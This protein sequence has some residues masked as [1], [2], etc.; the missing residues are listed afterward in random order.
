MA[1]PGVITRVGPR[2]G[3]IKPTSNENQGR[4]PPGTYPSAQRC[5]GPGGQGPVCYQGSSQ[6]SLG[7]CLPGPEVPLGAEQQEGAAPA[8]LRASCLAGTPAA[9]RRGGAHP[10]PPRPRATFLDSAARGLFPLLHAPAGPQLHGLGV[11]KGQLLLPP[12]HQKSLRPSCTWSG[13]GTSYRHRCPQSCPSAPTWLH[14]HG[15]NGPSHPPSAREENPGLQWGEGAQ[16]RGRG[17]DFQGCE[18]VLG[19]EVT[20]LCPAE[21]LGRGPSALLTT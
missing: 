12:P 16:G 7:V 18:Q 13:W 11:G 9:R 14:S 1:G 2:P 15:G 6:V 10:C 4:H 17:P 21:V 8:L 20:G 5:Q 19:S 3:P